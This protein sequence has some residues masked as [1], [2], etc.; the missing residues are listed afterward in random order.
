MS[1]EFGSIILWVSVII[2]SII[3]E[4]ISLNLTSIWFAAGALAA[5]V[6]ATID[7]GLPMQVVIFIFIS[8]L[9]L[10]LVR[11]FTRRFLR[12]RGANTNADRIIGQEA[13]VTEAI[14]NTLATGEIKIFGQAWS[15]RSADGA[16]I[17]IGQHVKIISI[18]GVKAIVERL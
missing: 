5:L 14:D 10:A 4:A 9:L 16:T 11:P 6:A 3:V 8:A 18:A 15:A 7:L 13:V 12:P 1:P 17:D 2:I